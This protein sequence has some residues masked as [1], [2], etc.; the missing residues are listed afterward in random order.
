MS[1]ENIK[2]VNNF[3]LNTHNQE[4][5]WLPNGM[6]GYKAYLKSELPKNYNKKV[7]LTTGQLLERIK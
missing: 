7:L 2:M 4:P 1:K 6:G 5:L 3:Y